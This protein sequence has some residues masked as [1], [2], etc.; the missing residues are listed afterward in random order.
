MTVTSALFR[1]E[2]SYAREVPGLSVPWT[3]RPAPAPALVV[4]NEQ[5]A[6]ELGV[7]PAGL[8]EPPG[9]ALLAGQAPPGVT[10][11]A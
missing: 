10:T 7:D 11:V 9:V 2:D 5:L 8:R 4:L 6:A 1:F 3:A